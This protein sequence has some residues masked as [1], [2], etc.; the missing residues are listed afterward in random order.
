[1]PV[2]TTTRLEDVALTLDDV[3]EIFA[4]Y[5]LLWASTT[6]GFMAIRT[7]EDYRALFRQ[8][9]VIAT[10]V[11][12]NGR[13]IAYSVFHRLTDNPYKD[14]PILGAIDPGTSKIYHGD[15]SS[16][17]PDYQGRRLG[18]RLA[19]I[20]GAEMA[21]RQAEHLV[22]LVAVDNL[23][24]VGN[25]LHA[26]GLLVG[27]ARDETAMNYIAYGG[28]LESA[29]K[30]EH[31]AVDVGWQDFD[32]Q[33]ALFENRHAAFRLKRRQARSSSA[34]ADVDDRPLGFRPMDPSDLAG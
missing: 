32:K 21:E 16:V 11:R 15:G 27:F 29:L 33:R 5:E 22:G 25:I 34:P 7:K 20:R 14:N 28:R 4:L 2:D 31:Q 30:L 18:Q 6:Y 8:S 12:D 9:E 1:M 26:G 10:G 13:L 19:Q 24:S 17:H 23:L 3:D